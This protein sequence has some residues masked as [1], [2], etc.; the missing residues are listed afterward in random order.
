MHFWLSDIK[1][2]GHIEYIG[3]TSVRLQALIC[4][5]KYLCKY[6]ME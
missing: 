4:S 2:G 3:P 1:L 6:I 5:V